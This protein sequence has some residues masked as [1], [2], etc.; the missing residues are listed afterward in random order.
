M[1]KMKSGYA[2]RI[3]GFIAVDPKNLDSLTAGADAVKK[4]IGGDL[5]SIL[6]LLSGVTVHQAFVR[7]RTEDEAP[8]TSAPATDQ[9]A[10]QDE[11]SGPEPQ[12]GEAAKVLAQGDPRPK[13]TPRSRAA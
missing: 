5:S 7:R 10:P 6:P 11:P 3:D 1:P 9:P 13:Q 12:A 4:A 8:A 2:V